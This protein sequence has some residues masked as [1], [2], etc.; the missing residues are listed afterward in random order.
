M[1]RMY[2]NGEDAYLYEGNL[3]MIRRLFNNQPSVPHITQRENIFHTRCNVS[4][5]IL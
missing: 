2:T 5:L 3:L 1:E 4:F